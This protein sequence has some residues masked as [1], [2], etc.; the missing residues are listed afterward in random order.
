[1]AETAVASRKETGF[2]NVR[3]RVESIPMSK[4]RLPKYA[5]RD[6]NRNTLEFQQLRDS[7]AASDGP[8]MSILVREID[9]PENPGK[10]AY[11][12]IDGLQRFSCCQDLGLTEIGARIVDMDDAEIAE[13]QIIANRSRI[14]TKPIEYTN[15]LHRMLNANPTWTLQDLADKLFVKEAWLRDRL[16]L[17]KLH[18]KIG[19]LVDEGKILLSYAYVLAKLRPDTEQLN[20]V[21]QAQT[22]TLQEFTGQSIPGIW[23]ALVSEPPKGACTR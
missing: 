21:D 15:Q 19:A 17:S 1:M 6:V 16:A 4:I 3:A 7:I 12:L 14:E 10:T 5:L 9:D 8:L 18:E 13:T 20:F 23:R 11:G 22:Q 2:E